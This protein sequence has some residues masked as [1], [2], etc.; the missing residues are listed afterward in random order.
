MSE[1]KARPQFSIAALLLTVA[2]VAVVLAGG[3]GPPDFYP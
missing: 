1:P 3:H 2:A